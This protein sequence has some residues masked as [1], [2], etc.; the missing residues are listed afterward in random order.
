MSKKAHGKATKASHVPFGLFAA[1]LFSLIFIAIPLIY[2]VRRALEGNWSSFNTLII[3]E[4]TAQIFTTTTSL[5][6]IVVLIASA[7]G[8]SLAWSLHSV[9]VPMRNLQQAL[10]ILPIA[11]PSYVF[12]FSWISVNPSFSGFWAAV[13]VLVLSTTPYVSLAALSGLRRVDWS[14]HEVAMTLGLNP[15]RTFIKITLPQIRNSV[16]A[17][18]LLVALYVLSDFGAV[19]LLGVDTFTRSISN[20]YREL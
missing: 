7:L 1:A 10:V 20:L 6:I 13:F 3:R 19:S 9:R 12:T 5:V 14:Q 11:I 8:V 18:T 4:K 16:A 15:F 17:G 2:L